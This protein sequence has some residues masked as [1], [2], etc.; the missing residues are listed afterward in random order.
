MKQKGQKTARPRF[1]I[2]F[3]ITTET[4]QKKY[5]ELKKAIHSS[6][7]FFDSNA[8]DSARFIFGVEPQMLYGIKERSILMI[9]CLSQHLK[10]MTIQLMHPKK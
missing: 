7:P 3:P 1:H 6:F 4:D 9:F 2:Y 10:I 8:L 5:G